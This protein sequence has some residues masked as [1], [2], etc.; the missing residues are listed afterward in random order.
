MLRRLSKLP[1]SR[2]GYTFTG[3]SD[4][5]NAYHPGDELTVTGNTTLTAQWSSNSTP[6]DPVEPTDTPEQPDDPLPPQTGDNSNIALWIFLMLVAGAAL[7]GTTVYT[8][9]KK[10]SR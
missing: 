1:P 10:R 7:T 9:K 6:E 5:E 4:G 3:W 2:N 8:H